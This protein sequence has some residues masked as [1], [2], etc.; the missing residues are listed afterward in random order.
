MWKKHWL[1]DIYASFAK[2]E[3]NVLLATHSFTTIILQIG[4]KCC[5]P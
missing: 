4:Q 2:E 1:S 5:S 3:A